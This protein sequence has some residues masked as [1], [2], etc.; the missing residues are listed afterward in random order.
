MIK[1]SN[2]KFRW[3]P[4]DSLVINVPLLKVEKGECL[5]ISGPS[6]SGKSTLLNLL[7]GVLEP[8]S[9]EIFLMGEDITTMSSNQRDIYRADHLGLLFQ[10]FNLMPFLSV[11]DNVTLPCLFSESRRHSAVE[12]SGSIDAEAIR[13]LHHMGLDLDEIGDRSVNLLSTGQQQRVA[14]ARALLGTPEFIIADEPTSA[15]DSDARYAFLELLFKEIKTV[16]S[17]MVFVSHDNNLSS[18]FDN[19]VN[20]NDVNL[21]VGI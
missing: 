14:A 1:I 6:G 8:E 12:R 2:V 19:A 3:Q 20:L 7:G 11:L 15:L 4:A 9:G 13:L 16:G 17:T 18:L 21:S 10:M 5:F